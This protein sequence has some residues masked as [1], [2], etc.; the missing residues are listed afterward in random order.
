MQA[1]P[2]DLGLLGPAAFGYSVDFWDSDLIAS[3]LAAACLIAAGYFFAA[4]P[5][6]IRSPERASA[7][8]NPAIPIY[9]ALPAPRTVGGRRW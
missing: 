5:P 9:L 7:D 1:Q 6:Q 4:K 3:L 2:C 8:L